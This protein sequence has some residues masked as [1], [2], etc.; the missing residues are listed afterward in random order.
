MT[1]KP[2]RPLKFH[3]VDEVAELFGVSKRTVWRWI[4][5]RELLVHRFGKNVRISDG[6]LHAF[7]DKNGEN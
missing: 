5:Q 6:N 4:K 2:P 7:L 1:A 3:T